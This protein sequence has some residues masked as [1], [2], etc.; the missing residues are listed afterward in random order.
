MKLM[1]H[2]PTREPRGRPATTRGAQ[3]AQARARTGSG[4]HGKRMPIQE[5]GIDIGGHRA[6]RGHEADK[7]LDGGAHD[8]AGLDITRMMPTMRARDQRSTDGCTSLRVSYERG[9]EWSPSP[10]QCQEA[11]L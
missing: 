5:A 1:A 3:R 10:K 6:T 9:S 4:D 11:V 7:H 2:R 8:D